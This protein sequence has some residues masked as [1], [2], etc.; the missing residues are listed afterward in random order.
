[1]L[2]KTKSS[3]ATTKRNFRLFSNPASLCISHKDDLNLDKALNHYAKAHNSVC[4]GVCICTHSA[5]AV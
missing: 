2:Q 4:T 3:S 1:M 5:G